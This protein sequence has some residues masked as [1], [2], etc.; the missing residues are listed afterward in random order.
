MNKFKGV[1]GVCIGYETVDSIAKPVIKEYP[2]HG[3]VTPV[4]LRRTGDKGNTDISIANKF[5]F[6]AP[7]RL[8]S[9]LSKA[10]QETELAVYIE[11]RGMKLKAEELTFASPRI[12]ITTGGIWHEPYTS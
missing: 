10:S 6:I 8:V 3:D 7:V 5:S 1:L 9:M 2:I 4:S 12:V 11:W